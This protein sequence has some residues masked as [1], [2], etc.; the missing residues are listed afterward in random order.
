MRIRYFGAILLAGTFAGVGCHSSQ[1]AQADAV[2]DGIRQ[3]LTSLNT[4]NLGAMDMNVSNVKIDGNQAQADVLYTPKTGGAPGAGMRVSYSLEKKGEQWVVVKKNAMGG[5]MDHPAGTNPH[6]SPG[7]AHGS[8]PNFKD[9]LPPASGHA[10]A[11]NGTLPPGH[12]PIPATEDQ[13]PN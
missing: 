7:A 8:M 6:T 4:L 5:T 11:A 9:I 1:K 2:R 10:P 12:P 13:K 3:Y